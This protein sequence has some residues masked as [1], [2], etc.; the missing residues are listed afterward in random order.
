MGWCCENEL[1]RSDCRQ[2]LYLVEHTV[3]SK[4]LCSLTLSLGYSIYL[5][6]LFGN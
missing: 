6:T 2:I 3:D 1:V 4:S 5:P